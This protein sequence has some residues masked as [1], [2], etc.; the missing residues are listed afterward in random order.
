MVKRV[1]LEQVPVPEVYGWRVDGQDVFIYIEFIPG[2][3]LK[4]RWDFLSVDEKT[5]LCSHLSQIMESLRH[6]E[7][8]PNDPFIGMIC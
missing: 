7:Q 5:A 8:D 1:L 4:E 3:T 6:V 2:E